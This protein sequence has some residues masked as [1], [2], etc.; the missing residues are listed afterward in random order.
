MSGGISA[1]TVIAGASLALAA[2]GTAMSAIGQSNAASAQAANA[3]YQAQV[4][5]NAQTVAQM[6]A[7][8]ALKVGQIN[9]DQ[10]RTKTGLLIGAQRAALASE[11]GDVTSGSDVD[12]IGDTGRAG[13]MDAQTI[14]SN[15][16][17]TAWGY[18]VAATS[19]GATAGLDQAQAADATANLPFGVGSSL[20]G[21]AS[22]IANKWSMYQQNNP[23]RSPSTGLISTSD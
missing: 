23:N 18:Q 19:A 12:I 13:E 10:Q 8:N 21:G 4:A 15:A 17:R 1:T 14:R 6:N 2:G 20:L 7:A 22:S 9:E 3:N 5:R 16:A 11:G